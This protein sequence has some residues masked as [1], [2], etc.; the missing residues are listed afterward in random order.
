M[1]L[2]VMF[3]TGWLCVQQLHAEEAD[4]ASVNRRVELSLSP[5]AILHTNGYLKGENPEHLMMNHSTSVRMTYAIGAAEGTR[6]E[7]R[8]P[9]TYQGVGVEWNSMNHLLGRPVSAFVYQISRLARISDRLS[10]HYEWNLGLTFG[11]HPYDPDT[12]PDNRVIGSRVTACLHGAM[13]LC[14]RLSPW[15]D[16]SAGIA[17]N[18]YSNGNTSIPNGGL[19]TLGPTL[20]LA[21]YPDR[22]QSDNAPKAV[23]T[24]AD[25]Q[26]RRLD[27]D[28]LLYAAYRR[29]GYMTDKWGSVALPNKFLVVG[30]NINPM[31]RLNRRARVGASADVVMDRGANIDV[32]DYLVRY[33]KNGFHPVD[34][35]TPPLKRQTALGLSARGEL[36]LPWFSI[37]AGL[38]RNII[39]AHGDLNR[40]YQ[41]LAL[42]IAV[43]PRTFVHIGYTLQD[44][45]YP[46]HLML[47]VGYSL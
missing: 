27:C 2:G 28:I 25:E 4:T 44:F 32:N 14:W 47:G 3:L 45:E 16:L 5:S 35:K 21:C 26:P 6:Q 1:K 15:A 10:A 7:R 46:N 17:F 36:T 42:K 30:M 9:D 38:G 31:V 34:P 8:Y 12:N 29:Q 20:S 43:L 22:R 40:W 24:T 33:S 18:H 37:N 11:W 39:G 41:V 23:P 19:N 13:S